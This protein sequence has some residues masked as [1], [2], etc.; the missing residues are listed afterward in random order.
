MGDVF[1]AFEALAELRKLP[2]TARAA[3]TEFAEQIGLETFPE[4][5][6]LVRKD[7]AGK[8]E[9]VAVSLDRALLPAPEPEAFLLKARLD[10]P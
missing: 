1:D 2:A 7:A 10:K 4:V 3:V 6:A 8:W 5:W 9:L